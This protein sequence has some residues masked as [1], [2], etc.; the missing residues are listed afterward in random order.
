MEKANIKK[1]YKLVFNQG[2]VRNLL[3]MNVPIHD[4]KP[5][6][7]NPERTVFVFKRTPEFEAAFE[8]IN[9]EITELKNTQT[10]E[11]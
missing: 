9:N 3:R 5:D 7:T 10:K 8:K 11:A 4:I 1:E 6:R 2:V